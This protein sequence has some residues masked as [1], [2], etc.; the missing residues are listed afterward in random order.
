MDNALIYNDHSGS[1]AWHASGSGTR[2]KSLFASYSE[3][4]RR[5]LFFSEEKNQKT[6]VFGRLSE[7]PGLGRATNASLPRGY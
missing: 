2:N 1:I 5:V 6:F 4:K 3:D 7:N